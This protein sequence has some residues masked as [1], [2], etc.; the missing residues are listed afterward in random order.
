MKDNRTALIA[1]IHIAKK[2]L[3][4]DDATYRDVLEWVTGKTSCKEMDLGE[5]KKVLMQLKQLGFTPT[6]TATQN[7]T[8]TW[9]KKPSTT[10]PKQAL[11][12]KIEAV[13]ADLSLNWNYAHALAKKMF[14]VDMVHWLDTDRL[15]KVVQALAVYQKRQEKK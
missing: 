4:Y 12:G 1:K 11:I 15:Y 9:G 8:P 2:H 6:P 7:Q 3:G 13:L 5:L 14:G 10:K